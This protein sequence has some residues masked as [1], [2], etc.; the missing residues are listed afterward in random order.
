MGMVT[1]I[2][3]RSNWVNRHGQLWSLVLVAGIFGGRII[4]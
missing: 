1:S 4:K 3:D 2:K